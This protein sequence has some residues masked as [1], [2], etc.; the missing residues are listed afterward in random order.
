MLVCCICYAGQI[1]VVVV[2]DDDDDDDDDDAHSI[3]Y[4]LTECTSR[5]LRQL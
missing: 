1:V 2:D 3:S 5:K 4:F